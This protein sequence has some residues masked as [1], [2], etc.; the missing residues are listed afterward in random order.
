MWLVIDGANGGHSV[1]S[2]S[3]WENLTVCPLVSNLKTRIDSVLIGI[4]FISNIMR[5]FLT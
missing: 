4:V 3:Y 1:Q 2:D 5:Y